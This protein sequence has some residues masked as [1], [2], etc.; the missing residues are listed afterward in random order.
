[1]ISNV[2]IRSLDAVLVERL[3]QPLQRERVVQLVMQGF[4]QLQKK[5]VPDLVT[6]TERLE[7]RV[8]RMSEQV[9]LHF[10]NGRLV[11]TVAGSSEA[12]MTEL[13]RGS[14]WYEPWERVDEIVLAAILTDPSSN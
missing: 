4:A 9:A 5:P 7:E 8:R 3:R 12:L 1:M 2:L 10:V 11:V 13:R 6:R 14:D